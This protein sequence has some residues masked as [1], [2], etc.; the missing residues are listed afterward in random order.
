MADLDKL[1][2]DLVALHRLGVDDVDRL[3]ED[4]KDQGEQVDA[5]D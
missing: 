3:A 4:F 5:S 1:E 2:G